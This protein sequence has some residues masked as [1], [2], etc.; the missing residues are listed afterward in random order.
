MMG[1]CAPA[2]TVPAISFA[3][4][5][6]DWKA[7]YWEAQ[8]HIDMLEELVSKYDINRELANHIEVQKMNERYLK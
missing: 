1:L 5:E 3:K 8:S 2:L 7:K 6:V 4:K